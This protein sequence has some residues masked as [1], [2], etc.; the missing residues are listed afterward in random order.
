MTSVKELLGLDD[1]PLDSDWDDIHDLWNDVEAFIRAHPGHKV[2][3]ADD[4][5]CNHRPPRVP[6]MG[7]SAFR[8]GH[9]DEQAKYW[10]I[11]LQNLKR[12]TPRFTTMR[13]WP[14]AEVS[15]RQKA[16]GSSP[17]S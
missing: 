7:W 10:T 1:S 2:I 4:P 15:G 8:E 16:V 13:P 9:R 3:S 12:S 11:T 17:S 5:G 6:R 14:S